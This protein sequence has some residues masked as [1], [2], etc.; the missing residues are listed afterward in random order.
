MWLVVMVQLAAPAK[1]GS[2]VRRPCGFRKV[3]EEGGPFQGQA[4]HSPGAS[5]LHPGLSQGSGPALWPPSSCAACRALPQVLEWTRE[6]A[7]PSSIPHHPPHLPGA[8]SWQRHCR[9]A[10]NEN[11][12]TLPTCLRSRLPSP[13]QP[14]TELQCDTGNHPHVLRSQ[15]RASEKGVVGLPAG[16]SR[17]AGSF[18]SEL[19]Q[20]HPPT[21]SPW[22]QHKHEDTGSVE[23]CLYSISSW[24]N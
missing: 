11:K 19:G 3:E 12:V 22:R 7:G 17:L 18:H 15:V 2:S 9:W 8:Q 23:N 10:G 16:T 21:Q 20:A 13:P 5:S 14:N 24:K 4:E 6:H 1:A